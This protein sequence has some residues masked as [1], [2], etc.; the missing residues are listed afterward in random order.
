MS[1]AAVDT[2]EGQLVTFSL[3][4]EEMAV[5]INLVQEIVRPPQITK[6][7]GAPR[8]VEGIGNLRGS[9]L[10]IINLRS[11]LGITDK[12]HDDATRVVVLNANGTSTGIV[13]DGVSEVM[14]IEDGI[15]EPPPAVVAGI[16]GQYLRGVAKIDEGKRLVLILSVDKIL[17]EASVEKNTGQ[18][19]S[20]QAT[21]VARQAV[22]A[23]EEE[24]LVTFNLGD[25]EFAVDIMQVQ[26]IIRVSEIMRVPKAPPFVRGVM[27]LRNRL[28]PI[29]DMRR[30]FG[31]PT[32]EEE[33]ACD[34]QCRGRGAFAWRRKTQR[35]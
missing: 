5:P 10:P 32:Q 11:R 26:E 12:P 34:Y 16:E 6:V 18:G 17:P 35:R 3:S 14:H 29:I 15:I 4:G 13:V 28:L 19:Q 21:E 2:E 23:E 8:Y 9:I 22:K 20:R 7:P 31:M 25:E 1:N 27:S 24:H 30:R 33:T